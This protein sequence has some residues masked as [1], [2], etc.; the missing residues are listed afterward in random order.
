ME[1]VSED[2]NNFLQAHLS[3]KIDRRKK[4]DFAKTLETA[5]R[6]LETEIT[7][8][9]TRNLET[10]FVVENWTALHVAIEGFDLNNKNEEIMKY[11]LKLLQL[12]TLIIPKRGKPKINIKIGTK[13]YCR[14]K[15][16]LASL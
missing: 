2:F 16:L 8:E 14:S 3:V 12:M 15:I 13:I 10:L 6:L 5:H 11:S 1:E 9:K 7:A 4:G